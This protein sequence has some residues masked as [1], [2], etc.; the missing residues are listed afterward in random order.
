MHIVFSSTFSIKSAY[1]E[2]SD[3]YR[4]N[5]TWAEQPQRSFR[6]QQIYQPPTIDLGTIRITPPPIQHDYGFNNRMST[7]QPIQMPRY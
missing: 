6:Q 5:Y 1:A 7:Y 4:P 2:G 3:V